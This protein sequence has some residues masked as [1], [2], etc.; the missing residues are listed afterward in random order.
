MNI[1]KLASTREVSATK[2]GLGLI[3]NVE[4]MSYQFWERYYNERPLHLSSRELRLASEKDVPQI[5]LFY[6]DNAAHFETV[7]SPKPA[8]FYTIEFWIEKVKSSQDSFLADQSCNF[9]FRHRR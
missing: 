5:I 3:S 4:R 1:F 2:K 8:E 9:Y 7:A 6:R